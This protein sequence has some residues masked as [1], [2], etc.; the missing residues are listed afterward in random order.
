[1]NYDWID[2][3]RVLAFGIIFA[4]ARFFYLITYV[5][6]VKIV[7]PEIRSIFVV[8]YTIVTAILIAESFGV[9]YVR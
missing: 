6:G 7:M 2:A 8:L 4:V 9:Q 3:A 5:L 1:M